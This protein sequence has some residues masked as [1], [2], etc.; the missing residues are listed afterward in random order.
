VPGNRIGVLVA[1]AEPSKGPNTVY[2]PVVLVPVSPYVLFVVS[3]RSEEEVYKMVCKGKIVGAGD[4]TVSILNQDSGVQ[5]EYPLFGLS[6]EDIEGF[7]GMDVY[8]GILSSGE[9]EGFSPVGEA[10][11]MLVHAYEPG[12]CN[13]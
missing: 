1:S 13:L 8:Y 7:K 4:S 9:L 2:A 3:K 6:N 11:E 5:E 12:S 10:H